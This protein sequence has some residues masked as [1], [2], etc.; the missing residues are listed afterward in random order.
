MYSLLNAEPVLLIQ[1]IGKVASK[2]LQ[3]GVLEAKRDSSQ[4]DRKI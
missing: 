1:F 4:I 3:V 2:L